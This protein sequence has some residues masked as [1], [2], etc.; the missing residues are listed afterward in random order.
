MAV[1][2]FTSADVAQLLKIQNEVRDVLR[3][4]SANTPAIVPAVAL[5]RI[6][7]EL[8]DVYPDVDRKPTIEDIIVPFIR[9]ENKMPSRNRGESRLILPP[10]FK[11]D[12]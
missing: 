1:P 7:K 9:G 6:A 2:T 12:S 5:V 11:F 10:G 4:Y 8:L 3:K